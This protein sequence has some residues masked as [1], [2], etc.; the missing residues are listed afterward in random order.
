MSK[1]WTLNPKPLNLALK[2]VSIAGLCLCVSVCVCLCLCLYLCS[3]PQRPPN[4]RTG[5]DGVR[6]FLSACVVACLCVCATYSPYIERDFISWIYCVCC[7]ILCVCVCACV[8]VCLR[9]CVL[10][11]VCRRV[12]GSVYNEGAQGQRQVPHG[13]LQKINS[14]KSVYCEFI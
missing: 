7:T 4:A 8:C 11:C 1:P 10:A 9:V 2:R 13:G 14:Q 6:A 5:K 12:L 3:P